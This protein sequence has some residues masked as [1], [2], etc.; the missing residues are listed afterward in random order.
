MKVQ[1]TC[2]C[3][4]LTVSQLLFSNLSHLIWNSEIPVSSGRSPA[5]NE[6]LNVRKISTSG[7]D[8]KPVQ[9]QKFQKLASL[10]TD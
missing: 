1:V 5:S 9:I 2:L 7:V 8:L 3:L 10:G 6:L 4:V